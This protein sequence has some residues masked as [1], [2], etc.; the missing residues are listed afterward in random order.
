MI[1]AVFYYIRKQSATSATGH[2][3]CC[4]TVKS[5]CIFTSGK[6]YRNATENA[7]GKNDGDYFQKVNAVFQKV[8]DFFRKV[9]AL[10]KNDIFAPVAFPVAFPEKQNAPVISCHPVG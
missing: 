8:V 10:L 1:F 6:C 2:I 9:G 3:S 7:T 4:V 5:G